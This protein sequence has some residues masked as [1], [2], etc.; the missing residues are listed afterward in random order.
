[1]TE[2]PN[3]PLD[4]EMARAKAAL[5]GVAD[6]RGATYSPGGGSSRPRNE[7]TAR[8]QAWA[9]TVLDMTPADIAERTRGMGPVPGIPER[10][11]SLLAEVN[12][13]RQAYNEL[14]AAADQRGVGGSVNN[15]D[16]DVPTPG[17]PDN[18][19]TGSAGDGPG[20]SAA[21]SERPVTGSR[22]E[23]HKP[24]GIQGR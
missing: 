13:A 12:G 14:R 20:S 1:M 6:P 10:R 22:I 15:T 4:P 11:S 7:P 24:G 19:P 21:G 9:R 3:G 17:I 2:T 8:A 23:T 5:T 16:R 18:G